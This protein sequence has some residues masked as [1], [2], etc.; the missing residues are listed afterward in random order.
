MKIDLQ[1][2]VDAGRTALDANKFAFDRT[3][4]L[5]ASEAM[6]CIR[7]Q[8]YARNMPEAGED[9]DW[10]YARRG[11]HGEK[12]VIE[13][14][15]AANVPLL[16]TDVSHQESLQDEGRKISATPDNVI[17]Y[18]DVWVPLEIKTIDP[19]KN[20]KY[21]PT[22]EHVA[23]LQIGMAL[24]NEQLKPTG[25][26]M[27][28]GLLM[29]MDASNFNDIIQYDVPMKEGI[30]DLMAKRARKKLKTKNVDMLDREGRSNGGK[31]CQSMCA[32]KGVCGIAVEDTSSRKKANRNSNLD[33]SAIRYVEL[34]DTIKAMKVDQEAAKEEIKVE[35]VKRGIN[36]ASVG[37]IE[38]DLAQVKGRKSFDKKAAEKAGL[39]IDDFMTEGKPS[40][41]LTV[42]RTE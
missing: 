38:I 4:Y 27:S 7:K 30:L 6:S 9:E 33:K 26:K 8:W 36:H 39:P 3:A 10:G 25:M 31:E 17:C 1:K 22:P 34:T 19:R 23:Q 42:A 28:G 14:L 5:N 41:R 32:F 35:L 13:S 16:W 18:D 37:D 20:R 12:Y 2:S 40:E 21:L 15:I 29:Y 11:S 24:I